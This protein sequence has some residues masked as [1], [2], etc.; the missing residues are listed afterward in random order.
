MGVSLCRPTIVVDFP[1]W[2]GIP[3]IT[4]DVA[5]FQDLYQHIFLGTMWTPHMMSTAEATK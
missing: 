5:S 1:L 4:A 2:L 3:L